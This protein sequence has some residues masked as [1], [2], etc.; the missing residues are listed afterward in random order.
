VTSTYDQIP[1]FLN[2]SY[3]DFSENGRTLKSV[4]VYAMSKLCEK[5]PIVHLLGKP[6]ILC[7]M[8]GHY[9]PE[10]YEPIG[11]TNLDLSYNALH[12]LNEGVFQ[13][14]PRL[15]VLSLR[16]NPLRVIDRGTLMA[17]SGLD[18]LRVSTVYECP[19]LT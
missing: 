18:R 11:I 10:S 15:E 5:V 4:Y 2:S 16:G 3:E 6:V 12:A 19:S 9:A 17:L 1:Y 8:Q 7:F 14:L 13:H